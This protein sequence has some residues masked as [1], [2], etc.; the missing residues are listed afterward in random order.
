MDNRIF[1]RMGIRT[2]KQQNKHAYNKTNSLQAVR[3]S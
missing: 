2:Q 1:L 3:L